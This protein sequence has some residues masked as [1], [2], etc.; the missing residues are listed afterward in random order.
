MNLRAGAFGDGFG[1]NPDGL[2]V[3]K[4]E[5][6]PHGLDFGGLTPRLREVLRT[7]SAKV[8]LAPEVCIA[9]VARLEAALARLGGN[10][11]LLLT[12]RRHVRSN[13]SWMHNVRVLMHVHPSDATRLG[14]VHGARAAVSS[15]SGEIEID[16]EVTDAVMAGVVSIPHGWGHDHTGAR[17]GVAAD[18]AGANTNAIV[19]GDVIDPLSGNG[20]LTGVVVDVKPV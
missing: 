6:N 13:N 18:H 11:K 3:D 19:P 17:M 4:L 5:A 15:R 10:G 7:P 14:L 16:V 2:S 1:K 8:E 20:V 12:G 9:D